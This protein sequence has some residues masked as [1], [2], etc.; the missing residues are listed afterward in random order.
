MNQSQE[1][2][3]KILIVDDVPENLRLLSTTLSQ[4]GY[5]IR[6]AKNGAMA[7]MGAQNDLPNLI[8][9]DINMPDLNGYE[10]CKQLKADP[11]TRSIPIIFLS[12]QDDIQDKVKAF[13][14][15]GADFIG[16]PFQVEEVLVR[17]RNQLAVQEANLKVRI[18]NERLEQRV[19]ERTYE[20][21][22]ANRILKEEILQRNKLEQRLRHDALHDSLTG[23]ANRS[24]LMQEIEQCLDNAIDNPAQRF[25]ILFIDLDRFKIIND[26]LGHLAGDELLIACAQRLEK[27]V[28][29]KTTL[30]RLGGDEFTILLHT[31]NDIED[32]VAVATRVLKEFSIPFYLGSRSI[33]I[34]VSI[35][36]VMGNSEY[37][38][39]IDLLR[40]A[41]TA[42]YKAKELGKARYEIFTQ[43]MYFDAMRR[44]E[45]ENEL[46]Q[47]IADGEL[48]LYY[49]PIFSLNGLKLT[50]FEAL[51]RWQHPERGIISPEEFI[52]LAEETGLI[53]PLGEWVLYQACNQLKVWQNNIPAA[54]SITMS[55]NVAGEQLHDP[56]FID[57]IDRIIAM[58]GVNS[59]CLK[60]EMTES[61]LIQNTEQ[62]IKV[63]QQIKSR[64]IQ[65]SIDDF[66]TGY[67]S[68][69]Y[70]PQF[71]IDILKIDRCFVN[72]MNIEQ[73]NLEIIKTIITLAQVLDMQI[74]AEGI[75]TDIQSNILESLKVEFGQ[76]YL[77]SK[78]LTVERAETIIK[79]L[80]S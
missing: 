41:D 1:S 27:C 79:N 8:L 56:N 54:K 9:L 29:E 52:P 14:I 23:L 80:N 21:E 20:V 6:C 68:L 5:K 69:S 42:L 28:G 39:E 75:E 18:L 40:D 59:Q 66:G 37:R 35:G 31:V 43:Q 77:F 60:L 3:N 12:A 25:A 10:V 38:Q 2:V 72:A 65:L 36:I 71:P 64:Q 58:T 51:V 13:S 16:K 45:L 78:P 11:L 30:A 32:A 24:S 76:G 63:L 49:Q 46:R 19:K 7:L 53:V 22:S 55:I 44:L 34:T 48:I 47:A 57:L 26:S 15:G 74:V 33:M 73:Q 70:L 67:S 50:G 17:V 4:Q 61:M 62:L